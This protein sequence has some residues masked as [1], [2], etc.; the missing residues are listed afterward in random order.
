MLEACVWSLTVVVVF[1]RLPLK[2]FPVCVREAAEPGGPAVGDASNG[3]VVEA[4]LTFASVLAA[5]RY[6]WKVTE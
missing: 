5:N 3:V 1:Q 2:V 6:L 4:V